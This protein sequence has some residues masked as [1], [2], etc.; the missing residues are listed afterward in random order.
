MVEPKPVLTP[1]P[2]AFIGIDHP[3]QEEWYRAVLQVPELE[4]VAHLA[5]SGE[6][7]EHPPINQLPVYYRLDELLREHQIA[8]ALVMLP[9]PEAEKVMV[10]L[11]RAGIHTV[12]EKPVA[13]T[14]ATLQP[15][16][17]AL[18]PDTLFYPGYCLRFDP[19]I[20][21]IRSLLEA[22]ILGQLWSIEMRWVTSRVGGREGIPA[23]RD[24]R[25]Y[26]FRQETS[27]GGILQWLGCHFLDLMTHLTGEQV[28]EVM[29]MTSRQT[30]DTI[31]VEDTAVCLL[32][33]GNAMLSTLHT[34]YLIP[35]GGDK[36]LGL[37]GSLG[38]LSW[39]SPDGRCFTVH[40]EHT[41]W[42]AAPT[43]TFDFPRPIDTTY[44]GGTGVL[45]LQDFARCIHAKGQDPALTIADAVQVLRV[46]DAAYESAATGV[47]V[48]VTQNL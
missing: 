5:Q 11:A 6:A 24:P 16:V 45:M 32:R 8:A 30:T 15:V 13:R 37:R 23:H 7:G 48:S 31:E 34:G 39:D 43:R 25:S 3:H 10:H 1:I 46:L 42:R 21:C 9:L 44:A 26:L 27:R 33:F 40:S 38:W 35:E 17:E 36:F 28:V 29:A 22:G 41:D 4:P 20:R 12:A 19:A 18:R 2:M 14:V 47:A